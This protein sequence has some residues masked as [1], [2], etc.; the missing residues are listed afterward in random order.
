MIKSACELME[1]FLHSQESRKIISASSGHC[2]IDMLPSFL[3][4][5]IS[6]GS[7]LCGMK[8]ESWKETISPTTSLSYLNAS[9]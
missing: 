6:K 8:M 9:P 2:Y 4:L 1:I 3:K 5:S 7:Q